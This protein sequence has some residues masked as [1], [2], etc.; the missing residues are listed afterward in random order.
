MSPSRAIPST[1]AKDDADALFGRFLRHMWT[2]RGGGDRLFR[3]RLI[4]DTQSHGVQATLTF[5]YDSALELCF[6]K[7]NLF[8]SLAM[9]RHFCQEHSFPISGWDAELLI[10]SSDVSLMAFSRFTLSKEAA[11]FFDLFCQFGS[12]PHR[13]KTL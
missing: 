11:F 4:R 8:I 1:H 6:F 3:I 9:L 10:P 2:H 5:A 13:R 7:G 12:F